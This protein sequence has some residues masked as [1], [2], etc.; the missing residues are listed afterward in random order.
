MSAYSFITHWHLRCPL[1][2][3]WEAIF[4]SERWPSWWNGLQSVIELEPGDRNRVG[5]VRRF[6]WK[7]RLP[8]TLVVDMQVTRVEP[9]V[10]LESLATGEL[11]GTGRWCLSRDD[12]ETTVRYEWNVRTTK[13]WMNL[14][15]PLA[16]PLFAL[17][18]DVVMR[19]GAQGLKRLLEEQPPL[20]CGS[21]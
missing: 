19:S 8:Y 13:R 5:C 12:E 10:A 1:E 3:V 15:A 18:H 6:A 21:G 20:R 4:H 17:N 14:L 16:R 7:G 11:E 2:T 9:P